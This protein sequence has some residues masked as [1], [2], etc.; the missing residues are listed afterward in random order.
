MQF[1]DT[2]VV[3]LQVKI[4]IHQVP[5]LTDAAT[6]ESCSYPTK[7]RVCSS[8]RS[9]LPTKLWLSTGSFC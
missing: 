7:P 8:F 9:P 5:S 6:Q 1:S 2:A 3:K 4:G